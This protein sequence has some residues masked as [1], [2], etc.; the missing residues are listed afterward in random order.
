[1][2]LVVRIPLSATTNALAGVADVVQV[3][4]AA[5]PGGS[6]HEV[7]CHCRRDDLAA[8]LEVHLDDGAGVVGRYVEEALRE[9]RPA[10][11]HVHGGFGADDRPDTVLVGADALQLPLEG[12]VRKVALRSRPG[13]LAL[14]DG[15]LQGGVVLGGLLAPGGGLSC[16][17]VG[18]L[19]AQDVGDEG[20]GLAGEDAL[21]T[22]GGGLIGAGLVGACADE[23]SAV[24][25]EGMCL[26]LFGCR[27]GHGV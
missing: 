27:G 9:H 26:G 10:V 5:F 19:Q 20:G 12:D 1:M 13:R 24:L 3:V 16:E 25:K 17:G 2:P 11:V 4:M 7:L 6:A 14:G 8:V 15:G 18:L 23:A 21:V 22:L